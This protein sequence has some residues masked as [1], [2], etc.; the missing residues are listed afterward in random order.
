MR[1]DAVIVAVARTP[2]GKAY[3]GV[4]NN[5]QPQALAGHAIRH[6]V[7]RAGVAPE[8]V[9]DVILGAAMQVGPTGG[10]VSRQSAL[11]AGLPIS[12]PGM[13]VDRAC[14][15]G[16]IAVALASRQIETEG[17][18]IIVAGGVESV[19]L[20]REHYVSAPRARDPE[21]QE[22]VPA[23]YMSM[24]ETAEIVAKRYGVGRAAQDEFAFTSQQ[25]AARAQA[26][27]RFDDEIV[28]FDATMLRR[29]KESDVVVATPVRI[30]RDEG[31]RP[32]TTC[33]AL[34]Q[35]SVVLSGG[36]QMRRGAT[37]T[38][39]N[40]SQ[41]SDGAA[42]LVVME[43]QAAAVR[44]LTPLGACRGI[45]VAGCD[46]AEM[47]IGPV[48][49]I[50]KLLKR[51][52]L[53]IDDVD[54]WELNEAFASQVIYCR[55]RLGI[56]PDKMNVNGGAIAIGHPYGMSGARM[57]GHLLIEGRRRRAR[58]GVVSMC[59]AGGMGVAGLFE[60]F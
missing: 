49:A 54:L 33:E 52:D 1:R 53:S 58:W 7:T 37:V 17:Q 39:G 36:Q 10:N 16:V 40:S 35:L 15:S 6:A 31:I 55:D 48:V 46:P 44:G 50:P 22:R 38:A 30:E 57:A 24:L 25:R 11:A 32:E 34:A 42:A 4:F 5:A 2:I 27:G 28:P 43:A 45:A 60:I 3:R 51:F 59:V 21:L 19:S 13:C 8:E 18:E 9:S 47:G 12:V 14:S 56:A 23:I 20:V 26:Q 41:L 29:D